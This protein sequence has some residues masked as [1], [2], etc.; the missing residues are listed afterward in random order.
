MQSTSPK[1]SPQAATAREA[2]LTAPA[3]PTLWLHSIPGYRT[4]S[5]YNGVIEKELLQAKTAEEDIVKL[6]NTFAVH[7]KAI[8]WHRCTMHC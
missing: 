3:A 4:Q 5:Y 1:T 6:Y 2:K 8:G 7:L